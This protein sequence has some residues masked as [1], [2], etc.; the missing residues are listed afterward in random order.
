MD[1]LFKKKIIL[2]HNSDPISNATSNDGLNPER[3]TKQARVTRLERLNRT[4][5]IQPIQAQDKPDL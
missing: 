2:A 1:K 4:I 3:V 5:F